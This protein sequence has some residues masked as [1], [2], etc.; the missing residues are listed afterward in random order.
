[1]N[2]L[3]TIIFTT[4]LLLL[5]VISPILISCAPQASQP[6]TAPSTPTTPS[7]QPAPP[8]P[9]PSTPPPQPPPVSS[10]KPEPTTRTWVLTDEQ[11]SQIIT[12][13]FASRRVKA[14]FMSG[15]KLSMDYYG[16]VVVSDIIVTD[17]KFT[18]SPFPK[19]WYDHTNSTDVLE[20]NEKNTGILTWIAFPLSWDFKK[21]LGIDDNKLPYIISATTR[22]GEITIVNRSP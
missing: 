11:I 15:N 9:A 17:G 19:Y 8:P 16:Q 7:P 6:S 3:R 22:D 20:Y 1:M 5:L 4:A 18:L 12:E 2:Y 13:F 10:S 14:H 21:Q